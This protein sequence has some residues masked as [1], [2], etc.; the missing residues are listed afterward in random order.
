MKSEDRTR[1]S[2]IIIISYFLG[3]APHTKQILKSTQDLGQVLVSRPRNTL[4]YHFNQSFINIKHACIIYSSCEIWNSSYLPVSLWKL[5]NFSWS[6]ALVRMLITFE[7]N[8]VTSQSL[9][10]SLPTRDPVPFQVSFMP[11]TFLLFI[12]A[13]LLIS[14][15]SRRLSLYY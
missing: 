6:L 2:S 9:V 15:P 12:L 5:F 14:R 3:E 10:F 1:L 13:Q 8:I 4:R 11:C 7:I